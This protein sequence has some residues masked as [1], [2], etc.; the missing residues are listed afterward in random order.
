MAAPGAAAAEVKGRADT[1]GV[2]VVAAKTRGPEPTAAERAT[3]S[4]A[5]EAAERQL[6]RRGLVAAAGG[7]PAA[8]TPR[9]RSST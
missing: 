1:R 8:A 4:A 7:K 6:A 2:A 9:T 5:A 3:H